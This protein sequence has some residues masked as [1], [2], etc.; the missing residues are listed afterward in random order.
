MITSVIICSTS[1]AQP[2]TARKHCYSDAEVIQIAVQ[3]AE[4]KAAEAD[5]KDANIQ[6]DVLRQAVKT[7][8]AESETWKS[9]LSDALAINEIKEKMIRDLENKPHEIVQQTKWYVFAAI[10]IVSAVFGYVGGRL[11]K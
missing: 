9:K 3:L 11:L 5:L 1:N 10:I 8:M 6:I 4:G 2:D 7:A